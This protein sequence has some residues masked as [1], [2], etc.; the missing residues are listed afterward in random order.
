MS[1]IL[2]GRDLLNKLLTPVF[3]RL[4]EVC[5]YIEN[6]LNFVRNKERNKHACRD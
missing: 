5:I 4:T 6:K 2:D 3:D 1:F